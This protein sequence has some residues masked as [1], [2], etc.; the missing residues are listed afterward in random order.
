[1]SLSAF[2]MV[3]GISQDLL[4]QPLM[5]QP[6]MP[7]SL[8]AQALPT[9]QP[10]Q[11]NQFLLLVLNQRSDTQTQLKQL[12]PASA[13]LTP[14]DYLSNSVVRVEGFSSAEIANAWAKYINDRIGLQA[15]VARSANS[16]IVTTP[17]LAQPQAP[18]ALPTSAPTSTEGVPRSV[19]EAYNPQPLGTGYAVLV[20][21]FNRPE[22]AADVGQITA[23]AVGLVAYNQNP[24]LLAIYTNS[25][26][27]AAS[28]LR[29]LSDR[30]FTAVM[31][32]SRRVVLL[33][34]NV[35]N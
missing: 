7:P 23:G 20:N 14:C 18:T 13:V 15:F 17:S 29:T 19:P 10:P 3:L 2:G 5:P 8:I 34:R 35:A 32:D 33:K 16:A 6:L 9:C 26:T 11:E 12:L 22:A 25:E 27:S 24:Y 4:A 1:M 31:V 28:M 30:G 21:Y